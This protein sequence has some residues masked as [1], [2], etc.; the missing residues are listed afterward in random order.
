MNTEPSEMKK[1]L[2]GMGMTKEEI[3]TLEAAMAR[4]AELMDCTYYSILHELNREVYSDKKLEAERIE[5]FSQYAIIDQQNMLNARSI[6][7]SIDGI[8]EA[9]FK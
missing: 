5:A 2:D 8:K 1:S 7:A 6:M 3:D 9:Y 4:I